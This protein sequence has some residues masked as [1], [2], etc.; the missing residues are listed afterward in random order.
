MRGYPVQDHRAGVQV[1]AHPFNPH[2]A[3]LT[4][5]YNGTVTRDQLIWLSETPS[6]VLTETY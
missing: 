2:T 1:I 4:A 5:R 6:C 3:Q